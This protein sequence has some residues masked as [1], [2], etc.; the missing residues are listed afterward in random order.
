MHFDFGTL[1]AGGLGAILLSA[2]ARTLPQPAAA[3]NPLYAWVYRFVHLLLANF[4][5][6]IWRNAN[7][8]DGN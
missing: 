8:P 4:D 5:K 7:Q 1:V 3:G 6:V 2:A